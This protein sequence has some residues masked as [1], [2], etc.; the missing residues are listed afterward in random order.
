MFS[1]HIP[2]LK[3]TR[4]LVLSSCST[5]RFS[6][7]LNGRINH[8]DD[9]IRKAPAPPWLHRARR[10]QHS[11]AA[12]QVVKASSSSSFTPTPPKRFHRDLDGSR[13]M[14]AAKIDGTAIA[15]KIRDRIGQEIIEKQKE[16]PR[17]TPCLRIIQVGNR[18]DSCE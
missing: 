7:V 14:T 15:N 18:P 1:S 8:T 12:K 3:P 10:G 16:N 4:M 9:H 5:S 13:T 2:R 17:F 6:A 11:Q